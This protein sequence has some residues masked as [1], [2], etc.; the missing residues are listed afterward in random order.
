MLYFPHLTGFSQGR[1]LL[2]DLI[3]GGSKLAAAPL[4]ARQWEAV[5]V[6]L[7]SPPP[8]PYPQAFCTLPSFAH[9]D[10]PRWR[11]VELNDRHL[12]FHGKIGD[13]EQNQHVVTRV[14]TC[15]FVGL[16]KK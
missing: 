2:I 15:F 10:R 12:R 14:T 8:H 3:S 6:S 1:R 16:V 5:T 7:F 4:N 11:P 13:C 9:I